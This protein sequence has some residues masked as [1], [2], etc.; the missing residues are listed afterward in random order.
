MPLDIN[1]KYLELK[2][3]FEKVEKILSKQDISPDELEKAS[4]EYHKISDTLKVFEEYYKLK[5]QID[6]NKKIISSSSDKELVELARLELEDF[7]K[8]ESQLLHKIKLS[9]LPEDKNDSRNIFLEL[10]AGVGGEEASLFAAEL[11]RAYTKFAQSMGWT[12]ELQ[13]ISTSGLKG[14]KTAILYIKGKGAY[15]WFKYEAGVHRVQ[16]VPQ[17]EASGRIHTS[18]VTVAVLPE[19]EEVEIKIDPSQLRIDTYR[20]GGAGGQNVNKVETAVRI[21]HIPTGIVV[22]CQQER[23]QAQNKM[24]AMQL[25]MAKLGS[26]VR[27]NQ[28]KEF[29]GA[30]K[31][32]VG[33]GDRSE[34][35]RTYNFPQSRVTDH[36]IQV[37]WHNINEIMNGEMKEMLEEIRL[38][39]NDL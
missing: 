17:T 2:E 5:K 12:V 28:E 14:V 21:T 22:Q 20:A 4:K 29:D 35:I 8:R 26:M 23:S 25:L 3:E 30:R 33:T 16:R 19:M 32:Q 1:K 31:K 39:M 7:E 6:E 18:T 38:A 36:R 34:K 15:S 11:M 9:F 27:E 37:S 10:R 24:R 13:D